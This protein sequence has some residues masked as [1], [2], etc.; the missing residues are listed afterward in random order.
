MNTASPNFLC[1]L[2]FRYFKSVFV[3]H[4]PLPMTSLIS[5]LPLHK[6]HINGIYYNSISDIFYTAYQQN[7]KQAN[8]G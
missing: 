8:Y 1:V 2:H 6:G 3:R 7:S 4:K 5:L